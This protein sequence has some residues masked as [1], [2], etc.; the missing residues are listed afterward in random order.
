MSGRIAFVREQLATGEVASSTRQGKPAGAPR[1]Q[2]GEQTL[3]MDRQPEAVYRTRASTA[4]FL[5]QRRN[6][7][8][9]QG[10]LDFQGATRE[11]AG[12]A[13]PVLAAAT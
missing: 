9:P 7:I 12:P 13:V 4:H 5:H 11:A 2:E 6:D 1:R 10:D 8:Q 3:E